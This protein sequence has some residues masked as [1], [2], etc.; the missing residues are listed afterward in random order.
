MHDA[1]CHPGI[2]RMNHFVKTRNL[3][4]GIEDVR[5][6]S[7]S[8]CLKVKPRFLKFSGK[9]IKATRPFQQLNIDFK[10]PMPRSVNNNLY[11]L[12]IVDEYSRFP[13]AFPCKNMTSET[14]K[15]CFNQLFSLFGIPEYIHNDRAKDFIS[16]EAKQYLN[17][18]GIA[19]SKTSRYNSRGNGQIERY[20]GIVWKTVQLALESKK[21]SMGHWETVLP[22]AL[23]SIRS[24]LCT[25]TNATPHERLFDYNRKSAAEFNSFL[26]DTRPYLCQKTCQ[27]QQI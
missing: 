15:H 24:L 8:T 23:H 9:L 20:N 14:V 16:E 25:A 6:V 10:G 12:T 27:K 7:C 21:L 5:K 17:S 13:F 11:L 22:D 18:K 2:T 3:A 4:Y 1:L 19:N 26:V